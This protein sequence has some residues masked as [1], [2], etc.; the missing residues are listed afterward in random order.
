MVYNPSLRQEP[1]DKPASV[2]PI[3]QESSILDWLEHTGRLRARQ[4]GDY[5]YV[6]DE[7]EINDLMGSDDESFDDLDDDDDLGDLE[8]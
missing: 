5:D 4:K 1:R 6:D 3:Q 8:E 7:E 2:I